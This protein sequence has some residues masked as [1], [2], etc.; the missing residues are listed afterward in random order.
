MNLASMEKREKESV[1][2]PPFLHESYDQITPETMKI[3][4]P[5]TK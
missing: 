3:L 1:L 2:L 4:L 5:K